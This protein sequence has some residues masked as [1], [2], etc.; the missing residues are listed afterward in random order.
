MAREQNEMAEEKT[1]DGVPLVSHET[2]VEFVQGL[3]DRQLHAVKN[4]IRG[5]VVGLG[6]TTVREGG[7]TWLKAQRIAVT[8]ILAK[9]VDLDELARSHEEADSDY[10]TLT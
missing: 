10:A 2:A 1:K 3:S 5:E 8:T 7:D 9:E 6:Y 4:C